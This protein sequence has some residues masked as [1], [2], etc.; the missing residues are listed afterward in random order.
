[1]NQDSTA[2]NDPMAWAQSLLER[3]V[4]NI[5]D[6]GVID[7]PLVEARVAWA[8]PGDVVIGQLRDQ[9]NPGEFL[10][11]I[12]GNVPVDCVHSTIAATARDAARHFAMKWQLEAARYESAD[13]R[14]RLGLDPSVDWDAQAKALV[15]KAEYLYSIF[16]DDQYW[17]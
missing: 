7:S 17:S 5:N 6:R 12:G 2:D 13:E 11:V 10:W 16:D 4:E 9:G 1:M 15:A 3:V 14:V 8:K